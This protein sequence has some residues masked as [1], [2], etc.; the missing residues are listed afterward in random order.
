VRRDA[1]LVETRKQSTRVHYRLAGD[2]VAGF[3]AALRDLARVRL[4]VADRVVQDYLV[5]RDALDVATLVFV[6]GALLVRRGP[7]GRKTDGP[8]SR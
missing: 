1:R 5:A 7:C 3:V 2:E 6:A 4:A 8:S